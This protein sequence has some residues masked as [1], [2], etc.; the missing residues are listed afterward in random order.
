[1][2]KLSMWY[3]F[4]TVFKLVIYFLGEMQAKMA[5][6]WTAA[7]AIGLAHIQVRKIYVPR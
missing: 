7:V 4:L 2:F 1:M 3:I 6:K 5:W